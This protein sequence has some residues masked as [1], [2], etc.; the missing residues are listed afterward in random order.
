VQQQ[1]CAVTA[2]G[3]LFPEETVMTRL[4]FFPHYPCGRLANNL[5]S[6]FDWQ[7]RFN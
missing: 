5:P 2:G 7:I 6:F 4:I 3:F 1:T